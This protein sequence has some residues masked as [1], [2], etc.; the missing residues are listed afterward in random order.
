MKKRTAI[1][2]LLSLAVVLA[3]FCVVAFAVPFVQN[4][5]FFLAFIM[6]VVAVAIQ[7]YSAAHTIH[8][9][10]IQT[11]GFDHLIKF[12]KQRGSRPGFR[13]ASVKNHVQI[14]FRQILRHLSNRKRIINRT[15]G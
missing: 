5:V 1:R 3:V 10:K 8:D 4:G 13:A 12:L 15:M 2:I 7:S 11:T 6:G 9:L 14:N